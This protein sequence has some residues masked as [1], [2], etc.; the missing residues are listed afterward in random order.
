MASQAAFGASVTQFHNHATRDGLYV[1]PDF[2][3]S[4]AANLARDT[5]FDGTIAGHVYAQPLYVENGPSCKPA[6]IVATESNNVYALEANNGSVLW[7][8]NVG[9][10]VAK[11]SLP[12]GNI[13]PLGITGTP[14]IDI[15]ARTIYLDAMTTPDGGTT[16]QHLIFALNLDTGVERWHVDVNAK[17]KSG[18]IT[19][20][21]S[22]QNERGA[23][24]LLGNTLYVPYGGHAGDCGNYH[25]WIVG[26]RT[27]DPTQVLAWATTAGKGGAW[28]VGGIPDDGTSPFLATGNTS[29]ANSW[30]GGEAIVRFQPGPLFSN[31]ANDYWA[32]SNW[33]ALD[34]GDTDLGGSG[35]LL[36]D[37][38]G[39]T[40]SS[41]VVALGKDG[42][43][44]LLD[45]SSLGGITA[46][47]AQA[48]VSANAI[49]Q[50]AATYNT[51]QGT[52]VAFAAGGNK[53][54]TFQI[55]PANPPTIKATWS[56]SVSGHG[57]PFVTTT[58]GTSNTVVWV[59]GAEGDQ[60]LHGY[61][62]DTGKVVYAGG[63]TNELMSGT[64]RFDSGIVAAGRIY[65]AADN[66]V[67]SFVLPGASTIPSGCPSATPT[68]TPGSSVA[69]TPSPTATAIST[70]TPL[71]T[72]T[73]GSTATATP[74]PSALPAQLLNISTR[75]QVLTDD[76]VLIG[77][78]IIV[79]TDPKKV[80]VRG[81]GDSLPVNGTLADPT[82]ELHD[83]SHTLAANDNWKD[84]QQADIE[85]TTIPPTNDLESAIVA[86]LSGNTSAYTAILAGKNSSNGVAQV[87]VYD[88]DDTG[89]AQLANISTRGFVG[90]G[91]N[92]MIGGLILGPQ[93]NGATRILA[94]ALG[95]SLTG[96]GVSGALSDPTLELHDSSGAVVAGNNNWKDTQQADIAATGIA[97]SNDQESAILQTLPPGNYTA[98]MRGNND[99]TGIGLIELY[100]LQ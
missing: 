43:A 7:Q 14:V 54:A 73:P 95:A 3:Q 51:S 88:L 25:G 87:E 11:S 22:V 39:A 5:H 26:V 92:V 83:A 55:Q 71:G 12:C 48:Q 81:L 84:T 97:P 23:L 61:D 16:K 100:N 72:A 34:N 17:A 98:I 53:L 37:V 93:G 62:G 70:A 67:Y 45:R 90:S 63:S 19:F 52:Y 42:N 75:A 1:E 79:G 20:D 74:G 21:S 46:P 41:L 50:A 94:R 56:L 27:D 18:S 47:L 78:F 24:D 76:K 38:P 49:I 9:A 58:D 31:A 28:S 57:S 96:A 64:H 2:T 77:G 44:Y 99:T 80:L 4:A 8:K 15:T 6:V 32:P 69:P 30:G 85:A 60:R 40:P 10:P 36:V 91:D 82:L 33:Q 86:S 89:N 65:V 59:V 66:K 29:G 68:P 13:D 35:P